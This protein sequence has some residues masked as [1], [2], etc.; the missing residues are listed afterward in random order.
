MYKWTRVLVAAAAAAVGTSGVAVAATTGQHTHGVAW[1]GVTHTEGKNV[2]I[3]GDFKDSL[4]GRGAIVYVT[5]V[6]GSSKPGTVHVVSPQVTIYT[7][8]GSL[9]GTGAADEVITP[10]STTVKNGTFFLTKGTGAYKGHTFKGT[11]SGPLNKGVYTFTYGGVY[12]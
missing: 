8:A 12:R 7:T 4:F 6:A 10:S 5:R 3:S 9:Q 1:V 2:Y 11:F